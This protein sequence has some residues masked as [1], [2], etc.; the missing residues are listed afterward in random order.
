MRDSRTQ[1]EE[2]T[3][4]GWLILCLCSRRTFADRYLYWHMLV[5]LTASH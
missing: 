4:T 5:T 1:H 2:C 3:Y